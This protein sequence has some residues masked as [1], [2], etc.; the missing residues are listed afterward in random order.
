MKKYLPIRNNGFYRWPGSHESLCDILAF[1]AFFHHFQH[2]DVMKA[3]PKTKAFE[4]SLKSISRLVYVSLL[5]L[6]GLV[7]E[8]VQKTF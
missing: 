8:G 7:V 5:D 6:L 1:R 4:L 3:K 2:V